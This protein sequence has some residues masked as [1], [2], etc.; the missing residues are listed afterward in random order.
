MLKWQ[1][2]AILKWKML[3]W[4]RS[5]NAKKKSQILKNSNTEKLNCLSAILQKYGY[6]GIVKCWNS[7]ML[8]KWKS[9]IQKLWNAKK[10]KY[11][12]AE[13]IKGWNDK[14]IIC[15]YADKLK[16]WSADMLKD[17]TIKMRKCWNTELLKAK[18]TWFFFYDESIAGICWNWLK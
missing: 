17:W 1:N 9:E 10:L 18:K 6:T 15:Q 4:L 13:I 14:M 16:Y 8:I 11:R 2:V 3:N 5:W 12:S 7:R